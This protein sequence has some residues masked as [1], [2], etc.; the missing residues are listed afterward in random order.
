MEECEWSVID[1][2]SACLVCD[3]LQ[4][5]LN[6]PVS[7]PDGI[8]DATPSS[9]RVFSALRALAEEF[10]AQFREQFLEMCSQLEGVSE[11]SAVR[12]T[13]EG[14]ANELFND[15][16]KWARI[17]ALF[18][19]GGELAAHYTKKRGGAQELVD[20]IAL[21][22]AAYVSAKLLPW[23]NDHGGWEGLVVF[24]EGSEGD[25]NSRESRWPSV[26]N[27]LCL[28]ISAIGALTIGAVLAKS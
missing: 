27:L 7:L 25:S 28:G 16:I 10:N 24:Y 6:G 21:T 12:Q 17:V 26:R 14:V 2:M 22:V 9:S 13:V 23:I 5:R 19:F 11:S 18:V 8:R 20:S 1:R 4:H 15:G 3:F